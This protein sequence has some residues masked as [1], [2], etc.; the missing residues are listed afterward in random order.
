MTKSTLELNP[1]EIVANVKNAENNSQIRQILINAIGH[2][3]GSPL[4][5][6]T[7]RARIRTIIRTP[8]KDAGLID[9]SEICMAIER[10]IGFQSSVPGANDALENMNDIRAKYQELIATPE[11]EA[12]EPEA[13][14]PQATI[15]ATQWIE[16]AKTLITSDD[17]H[18]VALAIMMLTGRRIS[19][20]A[21]VMTFE[22]YDEFS[23][24]ISQPAKKPY[25]PNINYEIPCLVPSDWLELQIERYKLLAKPCLSNAETKKNLGVKPT[26]AFHDDR[27]RLNIGSSYYEL[28][29]EFI[30]DKAGSDKNDLEATTHKLRSVYAAIL[31]TAKSLTINNYHHSKDEHECMDFVKGCLTHENIGST[32]KYGNWVISNIPEYLLNVCRKTYGD[33]KPTEIKN[34]P[35]EK[36]G[37][38]I[39]V[40]YKQLSDSPEALKLLETILK[41]PD[42]SLALGEVFL[43]AVDNSKAK[44]VANL[45]T[46]RK[47]QTNLTEEKLEAI[48]DAFIKHNSESEYKMYLS[49][50]KV[51]TAYNH[52][53]KISVSYKLTVR[54]FE[55]YD[56]DALEQSNRNLSSNDN[57]K[58]RKS[59]NEM[60]YESLRKYLPEGILND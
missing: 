44:I 41:S 14:E 32:V 60:I 36:T 29:E 20:A 47:L 18:L 10:Q 8:L 52:I 30:N 2:Y 56:K 21:F 43:A 13:V 23:L 7:L 38:D 6:S 50:A 9:P 59:D 49:P 51:R 22:S 12:V 26:K 5:T 46:P 40:L 37:I 58:Y 55:N 24:K 31:K 34:E 19:E 42:I 35:I 16:K 1:L 39:K 28:L 48:I 33:L 25:D 54:I 53:F 3:V 17:P 11:A 27:Y 45:I 57:M 15:D 4:A